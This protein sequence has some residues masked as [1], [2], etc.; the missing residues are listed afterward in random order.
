VAIDAMADRPSHEFRA[1]AVLK[2][3]RTN[4]AVNVGDVSAGRR[5]TGHALVRGQH[6]LSGRRAA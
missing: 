1:D 5:D 4:S 2:H 3:Q 6:I